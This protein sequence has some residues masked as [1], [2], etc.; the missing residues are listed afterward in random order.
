MKKGELA[1]M[2]VLAAGTGILLTA[3]AIMPGLTIGLNAIAEILEEKQG[4]VPKRKLKRAVRNLAR[5]KIISIKEVD[6]ELLVSFSEEG[7]KLF[8]KY[9]I[10]EL[11]IKKP[12][13]WDGKWRVVIFDIPE[14]KRLA[15]DVLRNKLKELGFYS[16]QKSVFVYPYDCQREIELIKTVYEIGPYVYFLLVEGIDRQKRLEKFFK[17]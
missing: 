3:T 5:K 4:R 16:L 17:I 11:K 10:D 2:I 14:K 15:R 12:K 7:K 9:K 13:R 1:K 6:G 8:Y